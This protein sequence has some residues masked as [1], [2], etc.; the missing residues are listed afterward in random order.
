MAVQDVDLVERLR[1]YAA[2]SPMPAATTMEEAAKEIERLRK[3]LEQLEE[4]GA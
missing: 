4:D 2:V 3:R 1:L